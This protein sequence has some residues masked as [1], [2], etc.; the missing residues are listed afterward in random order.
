MAKTDPK[1]LVKEV[2]EEAVDIISNLNDITATLSKNASQ[3][4]KA[5]GETAKNFQNNFNVA[6]NLGEELKKINENS[7]KS[8]KERASVEDKVKN[9]QKELIGLE[10]QRNL[11]QSRANQA[12]GE[13]KKSLERIASL[14]SDAIYYIKS[15]VENAD[16]LKEV[17]VDIEKNLGVTGK[18]LEGINEIP[19]LNKFVDTKKALE[20]A[21]EE[22]AKL[23]G[24]RMKVLVAAVGTVGKTIVEKIKDP[25]IYLSLAGGAVSTLVHLFKEFDSRSVD[26]ARNFG[27]TA[28][29]AR[30]TAEEIADIAAHSGN[31]LSTTGN[32]TEAFND[33][34][35]IAG[36]YANITEETLESYNDLV[37]GFGLSKEAAQTQYKFSVL[38]GKNFKEFTSELMG[39]VGLQKSRNQLALSDKEIMESI[40]KTTATQRLNI[41]GGTEGLIDSVIQAKKLGVE[42]SQLDGAAS[43]LLNFEDSISA[44][45]EAELLTGKNLN[46]EKARTAA[47]NNDMAGFA[48]EIAAQG[49]TAE[50]FSKMNRIQQESISKALGFSR[51]EMGGMLENQQLLNA[52]NKLGAKDADD[53]AAKYNKAV[54][55]EKFLAQIG[56]AKLKAQVKNITFQEKLNNLTEKLKDIFVTKLEPIFS[57]LLTKFDKFLNGGGFDAIS[58]T[59]GNIVGFLTNPAVLSSFG[60]LGAIMAGKGIKDK[61]T[62]LFGGKRDGDGKPF[63]VEVTNNSSGG[64]GDGG[65][66]GGSIMDTLSDALGGGEDETPT[67]NKKTG[68]YHNKKGKMVSGK[69]ALQSRYNRRF[70]GKGFGS[71]LGKFGKGIGG[72]LGG[73]KGIG[74][75]ALGGIAASYVGDQIGGVE[76]STFSGAGEG[77]SMGAMLGPW[78]ALAG[79]LIGG[80]KS[81]YD[82]SIQENENK[83]QKQISNSPA[84]QA[85]RRI[86]ER[87]NKTNTMD[88]RYESLTGHTTDSGVEKSNE[89]LEKISGQLSEQR[90]IVMSG[91]KVGSAIAVGNYQQH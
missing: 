85:A 64:G 89:L 72:K 17:F 11:I 29:S 66:E 60:V 53:L 57:K 86:E 18:L 67:Y 81:Y 87:L 48:K 70:G 54:D 46:L 61:L 4:Q 2:G 36:T 10:R 34:N 5:F 38:T 78:G 7:L 50:K 45:L 37:K 9:A 56:D 73:L 39:Q 83:R 55:K 25:L 80:A 63:L 71:K 15:Q 6:Q 49:I 24:T 14:Y 12:V 28:D 69:S 13:Q 68:R 74:L 58:K 42:F 82:S 30:K 23:G 19:I 8:A 79:A 22:A 59:I 44:E 76:G 3:M 20:A 75:G 1:K 43:S 65:G 77:A 31:L 91:N 62:G 26:I 90:D 47:L 16:K 35:S 41:K 27:T 84:S 33:L 51:E 52:A 88:A 40:T 32:I 21:N